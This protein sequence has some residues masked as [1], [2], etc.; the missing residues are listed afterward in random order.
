MHKFNCIIRVDSS[1]FIG[2]GHLV[3]CLIIADYI[4]NRGSR[5]NFI[6]SEIQS[7]EEIENNG[8]KCELI[9]TKGT[10]PEGYLSK[11]LKN[12]VISDINS[13]KIF[14]SQVAYKKY[15]SS[16]KNQVDILVTF[17][18]LLNNPFTADIVIIPYCGSENISLN[19][20]NKKTKYLIGP[21]YFPLKKE[22]KINKKNFSEKV[23]NILITMGGSDP[24][25]ITLKIIKSLNEIR[26]EK[27]KINIVLGNLSKINQKEIKDC[28]KNIFQ[29]IKIHKNL[30]DVS[31]LFSQSDIAFTNSGLTKYELAA[32]GVPMII[33]SNTIQEAEFTSFFSSKSLSIDLGFHKS[34]DSNKLINSFT[35]LRNDR[36]LRKK[37][38]D[39]GRALVDGNGLREIYKEIQMAL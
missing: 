39:N 27:L 1:S 10:I 31:K 32:L 20:I 36:H 5:I 24:E 13:P 17:E 26:I 30:K 37:M 19:K 4:L 6:S 11:N 3:R 8:Y 25:K 9:E 28:S 33:L 12:V 34:V 29:N 14:E 18:D 21:K 2:S 7:K 22:F 38:F 35:K 16:L 23:E 15:I